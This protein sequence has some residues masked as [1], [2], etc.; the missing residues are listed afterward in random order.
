MLKSLLYLLLIVLL[1]VSTIGYVGYQLVRPGFLVAQAENVHLYQQATSQIGTFLP[2]DALAGSAFSSTDLENILTKAIDANTFYQTLDQASGAYLDYLTGRSANLSYQLNLAPIK[3]K[4]ADQA[5]ATLVANYQG[6]PTCKPAELKKWD[7]ANTFPTCQLPTSNV[8]ATDVNSLLGNQVDKMLANVPDRW[9]APTPNAGLQQARVRVSQVLQ[10]IRISWLATLGVIVLTVL[11]LRRRAF[12]PLALV[13]LV[14][15]AIE[16][17]FSLIA[18]DYLKRLI[19]DIVIHPET[20]QAMMTMIGTIADDITQTLKT[21]FG[22]LSIITLSIGGFF[23][24]I[25]GFTRF[26]RPKNQGEPLAIPRR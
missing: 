8:Q 18:W 6:L 13:F 25:W 20:S 1:F 5:K 21:I 14:V 7:A 3:T 22:N 17:G 19:T 23:L 26:A 2:K 11:V 16:V 10:L 9:S 4:V 24:I 12:L 15:G